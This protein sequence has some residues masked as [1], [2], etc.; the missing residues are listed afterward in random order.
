MRCKRKNKVFVILLLLMFM[1][2]SCSSGNVNSESSNGH[3]SLSTHFTPSESMKKLGL[4]VDKYSFNAVYE[5]ALNIFNEKLMECGKNYYLAI[6]VIDNLPFDDKEKAQD[7]T[8]YS[9]KYQD[10]VKQ[11]KSNAEYADVIVMTNT[12]DSSGLSDYDAFYSAEIICNLDD[13]LKSDIGS[14]LYDSLDNKIWQSA[15]R[16][17]K[18]FIVPTGYCA[19]FR[20]WSTEKSALIKAGIGERQLNC[21]IWDMLEKSELSSIKLYVDSGALTIKSGSGDPVPP[22]NADNYYA[23]ITPCVGVRLDDKSKTAINIFEDEYMKESIRAYYSISPQEEADV[24]IYNTTLVNPYITESDGCI[25]IP[26]DNRGY[27]KGNV[28]GLG[29]AEW[30]ENK[31]EAFDLICE[32]NTNKELALLLNYGIEGENYTLNSDGSVSVTDSQ[33]ESYRNPY[34]VFSNRSVL[35]DDKTV[36]NYQTQSYDNVE[37]SPIC[38]FIFDK[39]TVEKEI[40]ATNAV[41]KKYSDTLFSGKG[42]YEVLKA[43]FDKEMQK[44]GIQKI[45]DEA[46]RQIADWDNKDS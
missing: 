39:E 34:Y 15:K 40:E 26:V 16:G 4:V 12:D 36:S 38:G 8:T 29:I 44:A 31:D 5:N 3:T 23:L 22:Y 18:V 33:F 13:Y 7:I 1:F 32:L 11:M 14:K 27:L 35:P 17:G 20:G 21:E 37:L 2:T 46:N 45:I 6:K 41:L 43:Q 42:D 25:N 24:V 28:N 9:K 19:V 10:A 30:S